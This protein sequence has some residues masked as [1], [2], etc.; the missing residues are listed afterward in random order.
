VA[1]ENKKENDALAKIET[2]E[3][4]SL[5]NELE[6]SFFKMIIISMYKLDGIFLQITL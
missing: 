5:V 3:N 6:I 4:N 2:I 1:N